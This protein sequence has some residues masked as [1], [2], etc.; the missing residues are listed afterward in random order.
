[1]YSAHN[2]NIN[3]NNSNNFTKIIKSTRIDIKPIIDEN[4]MSIT[5]NSLDNV[6][7]QLTPETSSKIDKDIKYAYSKP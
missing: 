1:M 6:L 3:N 5:T 4:S 7:Q 2:N